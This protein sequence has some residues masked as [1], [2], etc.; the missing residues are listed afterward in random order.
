MKVSTNRFTFQQPVKQQVRHKPEALDH[1]VWS[2]PDE[3]SLQQQQIRQLRQT[4]MAAGPRMEK[5][6]AALLSYANQVN[7]QLKGTWSGAYA[8]GQSRPK[9]GLDAMEKIMGKAADLSGG[10]SRDFSL[11]L[12]A[13]F[14]PNNQ[15][16]LSPYGVPK[17]K[18]TPPDSLQSITLPSTGFH[19][20][21]KDTNHG[22]ASDDDQSHHLG[23]YVLVG[24][25]WG[26]NAGT[27][28]SFA[29]KIEQDR[30]DNSGDINLGMVG[31]SYG[32]RLRNCNSTESLKNWTRELCQT[33]RRPATGLRLGVPA[34]LPGRS[35]LA[36]LEREAQLHHRGLWAQSGPCLLR[37]SGIRNGAQSLTTWL[38]G[39][40]S[41]TQNRRPVS[42]P[43]QKFHR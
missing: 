16:G 11:L 25:I 18:L 30:M 14:L 39:R 42:D 3:H 28:G 7:D 37:T 27:A 13:T 1:T 40:H 12:K 17:S 41:F 19:P 8:P 43:G 38:K 34:L 20:D 2:Q 10:S 4:Q 9:D 15:L 29:H 33:L 21:W 31:S 5:E 6:Y 24:Y 22:K 35:L 23:A 32:E 26:A 36:P